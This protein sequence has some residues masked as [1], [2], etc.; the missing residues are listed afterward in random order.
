SGPARA[1][2]VA[3]DIAEVD[4]GPRLGRHSGRGGGGSGH[5]RWRGGSGTAPGPAGPARRRRWRGRCG[6]ALDPGAPPGRPV[7]GLVGAP[8]TLDPAL[9]ARGSVGTRRG[10]LELLRALGLDQALGH[11][12][13]YG[14]VLAERLF[15]GL[16]ADF[17]LQVEEQAHRLLLD[18]LHHRGEQVE[19]LALVFDQRL[20]LGECAQPDALAEIIHLV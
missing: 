10:V 12:R 9:H 18:R 17:N 20:L 16:G 7:S 6:P 4:V 15:A 5:G 3:W 14:V 1:R 11:D 13:W 2:G 8:D 19:A